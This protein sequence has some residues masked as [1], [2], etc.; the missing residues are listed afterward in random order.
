MLRVVGV[1]SDRDHVWVGR[2]VEPLGAPT[3]FVEYG[4]E[5]SGF[6]AWGIRALEEGQHDGK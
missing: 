2:A 5:V 3:I 4:I 1:V 6:G